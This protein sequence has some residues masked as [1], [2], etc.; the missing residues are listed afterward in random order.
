[1][2]TSSEDLKSLRDTLRHA[3]ECFSQTH[4]APDD[5]SAALVAG[6]D[7]LLRAA[8]THRGHRLSFLAYA[9]WQ[10]WHDVMEG[11]AGDAKEFRMGAEEMEESVA[12]DLCGAMPETWDDGDD[13]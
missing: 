9:Y 6:V 5:A 12:L 7:Y 11:T 8:A 10:E 2:S 1:M 13:E 4:P 3:L